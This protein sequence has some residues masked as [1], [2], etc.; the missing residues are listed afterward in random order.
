MASGILG[1]A[2]LTVASTNTV[3]YS[4]P[5]S[6]TAVVTVSVLNRDTTNYTNIDLAISS[7]GAI[8]NTNYIEYQASLIPTGVLERSGIVLEAGKK[9]IVGSSGGKTTVTVWG[10]E[11]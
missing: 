10:Y 3:I 11:E 4:V 7:T 8:S 9:I 5:T 6:K 2:S 1:T